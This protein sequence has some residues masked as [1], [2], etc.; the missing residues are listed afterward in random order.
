VKKAGPLVIVL[1]VVAGIGYYLYTGGTFSK[2]GASG[3]KVPTPPDIN[4]Q[5]LWDQLTHA[6]W[7]YPALAV[8]IVVVIAAFLW[9][10]GGKWI[11]RAVM[12]AIGAAVAWWMYRASR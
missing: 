7:F 12:F 6:S 10:K 8:T 3:G 9:N 2:G 1:L 5:G 4:P 11:Q